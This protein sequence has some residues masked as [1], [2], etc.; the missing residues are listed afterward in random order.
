MEQPVD[1]QVAGSAA[2]DAH[3]QFQHAIAAALAFPG[4][5]V[6]SVNG[7]GAYGINA[8]EIDTAVRHGAKAVFIVS[9][10]AAWNIERYDQEANYGGRVIG[11]TLRHSDYAAMARA[12][13]A[14]GER[15]EDPAQLEAA[16]RRGLANAPAVIDVVTSQG[17]VSSEAQ[18]GL[19]FVPDYQALTAW[20]DA[21][22]K[23]RELP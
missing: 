20:D 15:V 17:V 3:L 19:G 9:N 8:M 6:I 7:D 10:N 21:E 16:I 22:R 18:K 5:Q 4:R 11:T 23:R 12:L 14:H 13:G 1:G 2:V